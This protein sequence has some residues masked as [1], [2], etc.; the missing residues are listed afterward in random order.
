M[1][2]IIPNENSWIG[3]VA[4]AFGA[5]GA[6]ADMAAPTAAELAA[7]VNLTGYAITITASSTGNTV[8]TPALDSLF[9]TSIPGTTSASFTADFYLDDE[10]NLAW[11]TLPR[12]TRGYFL[13][14][15]FGGTGPARQ[16]AVG[17]PIEVWPVIVSSRSAS[18]LSSNTAETFTLTCSV[19]VEPVEDAVVG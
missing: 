9:E 7:A 10:D 14:S 4:G 15:R 13:I 11:T 2:K 8:P 12:S 3:F 6:I 17:E 5:A 16:P 18:A 1:S 19:P